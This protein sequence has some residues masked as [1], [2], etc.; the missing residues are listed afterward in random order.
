VIFHVHCVGILGL[1]H[2]KLDPPVKCVLTSVCCFQ[3]EEL[4]TQEASVRLGI[5]FSRPVLISVMGPNVTIHAETGDPQ[6]LFVLQSC[7]VR[8]HTDED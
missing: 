6:K 4:R 8:R 5:D 7:Q 2:P 1:I 3:G